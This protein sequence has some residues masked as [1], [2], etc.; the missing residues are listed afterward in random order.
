LLFILAASLP[1]IAIRLAEVRRWLLLPVQQASG[2]RCRPVMSAPVLALFGLTLMPQGL[3]GLGNNV[4][5]FVASV[6]VLGVMGFSFLG[7]LGVLFIATSRICA[8]FAISLSEA[9]AL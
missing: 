6:V 8:P 1:I 3:R 5:S 9:S 4:L 2:L 7:L